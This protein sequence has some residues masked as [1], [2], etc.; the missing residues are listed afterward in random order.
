MCKKTKVILHGFKEEYVLTGKDAEDLLK[1]L[2]EP[3]TEKEKE[4]LEK[5][6]EIYKR[7]KQ[8]R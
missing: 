4:I 2:N 1:K 7:T 5:S 3:L 8:R 6:R